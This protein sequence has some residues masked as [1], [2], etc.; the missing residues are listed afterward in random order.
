MGLEKH[1]FRKYETGKFFAAG[2]DKPICVEI[3][4]ELRVSARRLESEFCGSMRSRSRQDRSA[5]P[6]RLP[7][8]SPANGP[9]RR[10]KAAAIDLARTGF[11]VNLT[12]RHRRFQA[13][14]QLRANSRLA[15]PKMFHSPRRRAFQA[16]SAAAKNEMAQ[17]ATVPN[18]RTFG[19]GSLI[20]TSAAKQRSAGTAQAC[21]AMYCF[22]SASGARGLQM[23]ASTSNLREKVSSGS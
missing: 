4:G 13:C 6:V 20:H 22:R 8:A 7:Q 12:C 2:V 1:D 14:G 5:R 19:R 10:L 23:K 9:H 21:V 18:A 3:A 17:K 15:G 11:R 16:K